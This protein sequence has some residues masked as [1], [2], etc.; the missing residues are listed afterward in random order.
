MRRIYAVLGF[1]LVAVVSAAVGV[2]T[3]TARTTPPY[4]D[5]NAPI[6]VRVNDLLGRMTLAEK[7]GQMDQIVVE[8]LRDTTNPANGNCTNAGGNNDPLQNNCL[9]NVLIVNKAGSILSGGTDN[10]ADNTGAGWA[11]QYDTIQHWAIDRVASQ[12]C[13]K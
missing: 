8:K 7:V 2:T 1:L 3:G 10:P 11:N 4:M 12:E 5:P 6:P 13:C 9:Q